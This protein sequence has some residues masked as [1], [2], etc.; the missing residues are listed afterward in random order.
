MAT[1]QHGA[2]RGSSPSLQGK[3]LLLVLVP[4]LLT[5]I[6]LIGVVAYDLVQASRTALAEQRD[7]LVESR[8]AAVQNV[9]ETA[10]SAIAP[11]VAEAGPDDADAKARA[12]EILSSMRFDGSNYVF[13]YD[14]QGTTLVQPL[15]PDSIGK[16]AIE[17]QDKHGNLLIRDMIELA[18]QG[19]G[20]YQYAW[21][22]PDSGEIETKYSY[23]TGIDKWNWMLG[24]GTYVTGIDEAMATVEAAQATKLRRVL[25]ATVLIGGAIFAIVALIAYWLTRRTIQPIRRTAHAMQDIAQGKGDLTRRLEI[26]SRDEVGEL[27]TQFNAFVARMQETLREVRASTA[28]VSHSSEEI[29]RSSEELATRTDQAAANLQETS[30]SMEEITS[31]VTHSAESAQ[32]AN[33]LAQSTADVA[34]RGEASMS[35]VERT[36]ND[37]NASAAKI[38]EIITMIDSIAFQTNI[39]ALNA[40]VEAARAGEHGRGFAVVAEEVRTLASRSSEAS[41]E[42]RELI[43]TSVTYTRSGTELVRNAGET[44]QEIVTS[45]A[46]VTDVIGEISAGAREQSSGISQVNV[47]VTEMDTMTQQNAAMV[48][49]S[50]A[51]AD[52]MRA[53]AQRLSQLINGFVLGEDEGSATSRASA[54]QPAGDSTPVRSAKTKSP[55]P[56]ES[57]DWEAF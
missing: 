9:I 3:V 33:Q 34:R 53:H 40:S 45:V 17:T 36:M 41:R 31:T 4:L 21:P 5:T 1:T 51:S 50:S 44:M 16:N 22:H 15:K 54:S 6:T 57:D 26:E 27:A 10:K 2:H 23:A 18:K 55:V 30:A 39:L 52:A 19:G 35:Q 12:K 49:H 7:M 47:A 37:I 48:Q 13:V 25:I 29:A 32:Q 56:S 42:I 20:H 24:A 43:D 38:G 28:Q 46:R 11:I 8:K 14:Y